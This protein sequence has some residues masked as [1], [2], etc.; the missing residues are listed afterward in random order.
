MTG[1]TS[2]QQLESYTESRKIGP[3]IPLKQFINTNCTYRQDST[4]IPDGGT[5]VLPTFS[6]FMNIYFKV[7]TQDLNLFKNRNNEH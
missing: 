7:S 5:P 2:I 3:V 1:A 6:F 4:Q